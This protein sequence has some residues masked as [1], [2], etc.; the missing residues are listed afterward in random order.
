MWD[1]TKLY[2]ILG[3]LLFPI[4]DLQFATKLFNPIMFADD[5]NI[6]YIKHLI[7]AVNSELQKVIYL[8]FLNKL[9]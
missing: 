4:F 5:T 2:I 1:S 3:S 8:C 7:K 9:F 6:Q